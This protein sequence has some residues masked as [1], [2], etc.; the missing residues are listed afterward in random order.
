MRIW[1][2]IY[3]IRNCSALLETAK[4]VFRVDVSMCVPASNEWEWENLLTFDAVI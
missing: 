3:G 2:L 4:L 1:L